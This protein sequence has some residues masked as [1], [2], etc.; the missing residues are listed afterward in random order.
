MTSRIHPGE[1]NGSYIMHGFLQFILSKDKM[2]NE[3]RDRL[4]FKIIPMLNPDGVIVGNH[5][6]SFIG[7]DVNRQFAQPNPKLT[8]ETYKIR[9]LIK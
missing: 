2:A 5:R 9:E 7:R 4:I 8:P 3:L 1:T 6:T